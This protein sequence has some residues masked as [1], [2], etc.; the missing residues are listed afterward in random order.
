MARAQLNT[1]G[2]NITII[3]GGGG[4]SPL[5]LNVTIG[6]DVAGT[7]VGAQRLRGREGLCVLFLGKVAQACL[8]RATDPSRDSLE[9]LCRTGVLIS[10]YR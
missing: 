5:P 10:C 2:D 6:D 9:F 8:V 1:A 3:S 7:S 4:D